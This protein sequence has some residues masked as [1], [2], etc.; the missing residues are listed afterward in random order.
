MN[1]WTVYVALVH[2][3][4]GVVVA[5]GE[6]NVVVVAIGRSPI[7]DNKEVSHANVIEYGPSM[8][9]FLCDL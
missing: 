6:V 7:F 8:P 2:E 4:L 1:D 9:I 3:H 5:L